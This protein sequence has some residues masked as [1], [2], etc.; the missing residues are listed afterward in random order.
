[1]QYK[2]AIIDFLLFAGCL[3]QFLYGQPMRPLSSNLLFRKS[4]FV[5]SHVDA[6]ATIRA[7]FDAPRK[8]AA[9]KS[10]LPAV[11]RFG[12]HALRK[13][14][15]FAAL[16]KKTQRRA[17]A[18]VSRMLDYAAS[19]SRS[20]SSELTNQPDHALVDPGLRARISREQD[21]MVQVKQIDRLSDLLCGV[22]DLAEVV[23][24]IDP[25]TTWVKYADTAYQELC[26]YMNQLNTHVGLYQV[27]SPHNNFLSQRRRLTMN[28]SGTKASL[29]P[30]SFICL[31]QQFST[32]SCFDS[33]RA[34]SF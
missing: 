6:Q 8:T 33:S 29:R 14:S 13:P 12:H 19:S 28:S 34:I 20:F 5:S 3:L 24:N 11:G 30:S 17:D 31:Y 22:I 27:S 23:R 9:F 10:A 1:M 7:A 26:Y 4:S 15:D 32:F 21:L 18:I 16:S 2:P 25:D